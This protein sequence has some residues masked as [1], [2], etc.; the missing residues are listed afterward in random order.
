MHDIEEKLLVGY[1]D[2]AEFLTKCG[3]YEHAL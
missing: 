1:R 2:T 3:L